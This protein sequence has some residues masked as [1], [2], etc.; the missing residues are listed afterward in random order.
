M[1]SVIMIALMSLG[2]I[3]CGNDDEQNGPT[4]D[5][6]SNSIIGS[7]ATSASTKDYTILVFRSDNT[8]TE[9]YGINPSDNTAQADKFTYSFNSSTMEL[10]LVYYYG[11]EEDVMTYKIKGLTSQQF[12]CVDP[13]DNEETIFYRFT[14]TL[15]QT[16]DSSGDDNEG[17]NDNDNDDP[18]HPG[19]LSV[20]YNITSSVKDG[21]VIISWSAVS[22]ATKYSVYRSSSASGSYSLITTVSTTTATDNSPLN[23]YNYYKIKAANSSA[24]SSLS[25]Y[26]YVNLST[27]PEEAQQKPAT[28]TGVTV[29]N[30]G[31]SYIPYVV[32]RWNPVNG[33]EKYRVYRSSLANGSYSLIGETDYECLADNN[34]PTSTSAYY[35]V[36]AINSS[37]ESSYSSY[38]KYTPVSSEEAFAPAITYGNCTV[39]GTTMTLR[40]TFKTGSQY[41]KATSVKLRVWNP[42]ANEWQDTDLSSTATS[43]SFS[44]SNKVDDDGWVKAG[45]VV[46]NAKGSYTPGA[47]AYNTKTKQWLY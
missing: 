16:H 45:I 34:A 13:E 20:P 5:L 24:E 17:D 42:Y 19:T 12:T 47:K 11:G 29:S 37:G 7:W 25:S 30:E 32:I 15:P 33:A 46:S 9:Y 35:K 6:T 2:F 1:Q 43:T 10:R 4:E 3:S 39:S 27:T 38:A 44:I 31:N 41:G 36:K 22:N 26:T 23:G 18:E 28:P 40:W 21:K 14:G 8:G